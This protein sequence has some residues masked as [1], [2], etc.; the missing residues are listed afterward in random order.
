MN[1][2][3]VVAK[4]EASS[5]RVPIDI[6]DRVFT[7]KFDSGATDTVISARVFSNSLK[8]SDLARFTEYCEEHSQHNKEFISA[9]GHTFKGY[10]VTAHNVRLGKSV[11]PDFRYYLVVESER[12]IALLGFDFIDKCRCS[13]DPGRHFYLTGFDVESYG[14]DIGAMENDEVVAFM[15]SL[16][17]D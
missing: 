1:N 14:A 15:D 17:E 12:D 13:H 2:L 8:E 3:N 5:Y 6:D 4:R 9:T 7:I 11:L 16:T 10:L